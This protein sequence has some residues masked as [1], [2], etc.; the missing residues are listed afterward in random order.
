MVL[1]SLYTGAKKV[2]VS[3]ESALAGFTT[4]RLKHNRNIVL[5]VFIAEKY[6]ETQ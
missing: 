6:V 3:G 5:N 2:D 1:I 4:H